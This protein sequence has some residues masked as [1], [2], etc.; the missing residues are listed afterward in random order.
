MRAVGSSS[1]RTERTIHQALIPAMNVPAVRNAAE[2]VCGKAESSVLLLSTA[3]MSVISARPV[4]S[5]NTVPT[6]CCIQ[7]FAARMEYA[8]RL[9]AIATAQMVARW[10]RLGSL[11]QPKI[12][13][14]R[15]VDS[16][17]KAARASIASGAPN[18]SPTNREYSLQFIP[19][20]NSCTMPVATPMAKLISRSLPKNLVSLGPKSHLV[21]RC[22]IVGTW[23]W[24]YPG[25]RALAD[26]R[27][28]AVRHHDGLPLHLR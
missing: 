25:S 11:S 23:L 12:H 14:P 13:R 4:C 6:G 19:N 17:K 8:D 5:L 28:V 15:N 26:T 2:M 21:T 18:T 7:E 20:W 24:T 9:V 10:I 22:H 3:P 16:T 27:A 1:R